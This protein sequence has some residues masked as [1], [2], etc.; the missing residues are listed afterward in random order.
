MG[1]RKFQ[2]YPFEEDY[3]V[4]APLTLTC[5]IASSTGW[6]DLNDDVNYRLEKSSFG[7]S[8][9]TWRKRTVTSDFVEGEFTVNAVRENIVETL[10]VWCHGETFYDMEVAKNK[11]IAAISQLTYQLMF[12]TNNS[13]H[14]YDCTIADY[15]ISTTHEYRHGGICLLKASV[16]RHPVEQH[17]VAAVDE[18]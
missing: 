18:L 17:V 11:L 3:G 15:T 9:A 10:A 16:P 6:V 14:Y 1:L 12:R 5:K 8:S 4:P 13:A 7:E 2:P